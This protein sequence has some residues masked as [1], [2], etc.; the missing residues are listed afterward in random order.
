[1]KRRGMW[2]LLAVAA[3][4]FCVLASPGIASAVNAAIQFFAGTPGSGPAGPKEP[5]VPV[6]GCVILDPGHGGGDP[7]CTYGGALEKDLTLLLALKVKE[8]LEEAGILVIM[9]RDEDVRLYPDDRVEIA[10][11]NTEADAFVSIHCNAFSGD[12]SDGV[13]GIETYYN[14]V[15]NAGNA[16]LAECVQ[17]ETVKAAGAR[18]RGTK[19]STNIAVVIG[20]PMP[21]CLIEVGFLSSNQ[22][23]ALLLSADYQDKL[24]RGIADGIIQFLSK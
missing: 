20:P 21:S 23:R 22:E 11:S 24:A 1:M 19:I 13:T 2:L 17:N 9:T 15:K 8:R 14:N 6:A 3:V 18:N 10:R 16:R 5:V 12:G 4:I 7:G